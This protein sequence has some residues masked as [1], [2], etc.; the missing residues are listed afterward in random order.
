M[1]GNHTNLFCHALIVVIR[2]WKSGEA[3][4]KCLF[5]MVYHVN[6]MQ[7][8]QPNFILTSQVLTTPRQ[9]KHPFQI[10]CKIFSEE[11]CFDVLA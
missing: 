10:Y 2:M 5:Y 11:R 4:S 3:V 6:I 9:K 8:M 1:F 7:C